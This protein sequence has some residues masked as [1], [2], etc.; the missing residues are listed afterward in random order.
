MSDRKFEFF[1]DVGKRMV[2]DRVI[3]NG[4]ES[5]IPQNLVLKMG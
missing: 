3:H 5:E 4:F 2:V 1:S